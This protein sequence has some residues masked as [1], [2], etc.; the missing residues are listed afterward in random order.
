MK[1][2]IGK[3]LEAINNFNNVMDT[4]SRSKKS[5]AFQCTSKKYTEKETDEHTCIHN[6]LGENK[7]GIHLT[8]FYNENFKSLG[9][10]R[11]SRK[12]KRYLMLIG[13]VE[14]LL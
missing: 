7:V 13:L 14:L 11:D 2:Y 10:K 12:Y 9:E 4:E 5:I 1:H 8:N 6:S 3:L